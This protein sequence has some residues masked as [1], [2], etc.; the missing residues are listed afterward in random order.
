MEGDI[1]Q[2]EGLYE[3]KVLFFPSQGTGNLTLKDTNKSDNTKLDFSEA[4]AEALKSG[5]SVGKPSIKDNYELLTKDRKTSK[6]P[7][8]YLAD[9]K[10]VI[11]YNGVVFQCDEKS[12]SL[13]L[14]DMSKKDNIL[15]IYLSDGGTLKV[16]RDSISSL[17]K[18]IGMFSPEDVKRILIAI[19][20]DAKLK[21]KLKEM[22][23]EVSKE[24]EKLSN[25]EELSE[26]ENE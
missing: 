20:T 7:Y 23:D 16:N 9:E 5:N 17:S 22:E 8:S 10:G 1:L 18:A 24:I 2:L 13:C 4:L 21:G 3:N 6:V 19:S 26:N 15:T 25:H 14:G 12:N 11:Q